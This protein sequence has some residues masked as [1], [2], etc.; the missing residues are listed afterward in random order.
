M[1]MP[2]FPKLFPPFSFV[3]LNPFSSTLLSTTMTTTTTTTKDNC[4]QLSAAHPRSWQLIDLPSLLNQ[5][6]P[7]EL[8]N[9]NEISS[10][11]FLSLLCRH[12][13][14]FSSCGLSCQKSS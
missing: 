2:R 5:R 4:L 13:E 7:S 14:P 11:F 1:L 10:L 8:S 3:A 12:S 9:L 6:P